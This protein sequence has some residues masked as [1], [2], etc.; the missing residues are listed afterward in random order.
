MR[1]T[2]LCFLFLLAGYTAKS[3]DSTFKKTVDWL[4][5]NNFKIKKAFDGSRNEN[6]PA[7]FSFMN[8]YQ[9]S[10]D[11]IN[12]DLAVKLSQLEVLKD[13][14]GL[15]FY[16]KVEWHKSTNS[17]SRKNKLDG[18]VN[19][20][21][22]PFLLKAQNLPAG[23]PNKGLVVAP[24]FQ[25]TSSFRR[26]FTTDVFETKLALQLS[27]ASNYKYLPG[28]NFRD[29]K[30]NFRFRYYPYFGVEYNRL[31][32]FLVKGETEE[33]STWFVRLY[34]ELWVIPRSLQLNLE[35]TYRQIMNNKTSIRTSLP[36]FNPSLYF[37][38]GKQEIIGIGFEYKHGYD[39]DDVFQLIQTSSLTLNVKL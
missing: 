11:F 25:G 28:F 35:G 12:I 31:P 4:T 10:N 24:W 19:M 6:R 1:T 17:E 21:F 20:E 7:G 34:A 8:D 36:M 23:V 14:P 39:A 37:Y 26:N 29:K 2:Y 33:F 38:P 18:G 16:P 3:Q 22:Y 9:S 13:G 5:K 27:L 15:L 30:N 32:D